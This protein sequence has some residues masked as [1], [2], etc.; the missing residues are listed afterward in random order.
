MH[1]AFALLATF[2]IFAPVGSQAATVRGIRIVERGLFH[3]ETARRTLDSNSPT[4]RLSTVANIKLVK[5]TTTIPARRGVEMGIRIVIDGAPKGAR[6]PLKVIEH[7]P[8][9]GVHN[10]KTQAITYLYEHRFTMKIGDRHYEGYSLDNPWEVVP[11]VW[12]FDVWYHGHKMA[13]Q[14]FYVAR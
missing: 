2:L 12:T 1:M 13:E 3:T 11:G 9:A 8:K 14:K 4:G 10:P 7:F 6:I 5:S